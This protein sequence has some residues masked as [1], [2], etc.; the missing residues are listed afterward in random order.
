MKQFALFEQ[1]ET[2][3]AQFA[4]PANPSSSQSLLK[5]A[6]STAKA[7]VNP[8]PKRKTQSQFFASYRGS[9]RCDR[10]LSIPGLDSC[11]CPDC[12]WI[13]RLQ[14]PWVGGEA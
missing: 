5:A 2:T 8:Q 7:P 10:A 4:K 14:N 9:P 1:A 12:G 6:L 3:P 13:S 11:F